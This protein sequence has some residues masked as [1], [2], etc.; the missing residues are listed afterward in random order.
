M[1][2]EWNTTTSIQR[3]MCTTRSTET[4]GEIE[5]KVDKAEHTG[6]NTKTVAY[7]PLEG[8][9]KEPKEDNEKRGS[10]R[11]QHNDECI[12]VW[13]QHEC[14]VADIKSDMCDAESSSAVSR[15]RTRQVF[16]TVTA[17]SLRNY[18]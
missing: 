12:V 14:A 3:R 18:V 13:L 10:Q 2:L 4:K 15:S 11:R 17:K 9:K 6:V 8:T 1:A 16:G 7:D 5:G